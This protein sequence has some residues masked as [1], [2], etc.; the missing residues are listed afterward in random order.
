MSSYV[1][2]IAEVICFIPVIK[3]KN[4]NWICFSEQIQEIRFT[5][6]I[7]ILTVKSAL[8]CARVTVYGGDSSGHEVVFL[9]KL[10]VY[11][12]LT[13]WKPQRKRVP[14]YKRF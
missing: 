2:L 10:K 4:K 6:W 8:I 14:E 12:T 11:I 5:A 9:I 13:Y 3:N 7:Q 1:N